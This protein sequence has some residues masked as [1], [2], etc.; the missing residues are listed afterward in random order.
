MA[1]DV[2]QIIADIQKLYK[3]KGED[4]P[5]Y[6]LGG[7]IESVKIDYGSGEKY[8]FSA[9]SFITTFTAKCEKMFGKFHHKEN[10]LCPSYKPEL[11]DTSLLGN[12]DIGKYQMLIGS[13]QWTVMLC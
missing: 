2:K 11:D 10:P 1:K 13:L 9:K 7:D 8:T 5:E 12:E 3:L 6:Y 4:T